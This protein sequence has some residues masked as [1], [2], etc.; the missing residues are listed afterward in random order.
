M[1]IGYRHSKDMKR[2]LS[3]LRLGNT[4]G[5]FNKGRIMLESEKK[6]LCVLAVGRIHSEQTK[7]KLRELNHDF[8]HRPEVIELLSIINIGDQ[9]PNWHNGL[10]H[11]PYPIEFRRRL[12]ER[13]RARD[14]YHCRLCGVAQEECLRALDIHHIDHN[15][16]NLSEDNLISL[17]LRCN[18]R[19]NSSSFI[20]QF[21]PL[22]N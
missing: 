19:C 13:I 15:K 3:Q 20:P 5:R 8:V 1:P 16:E 17:C 14:N 12:K 2:T 10:S 4:F 6:H 7:Q 9:N 11:A 22:I 18:G 21:L